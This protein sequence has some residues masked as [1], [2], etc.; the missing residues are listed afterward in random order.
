M[1]DECSRDP[2]AFHRN[3]VEFDLVDDEAREHVYR[4]LDSYI[5]YH[6]LEKV[7]FRDLRN[8]SDPEVES[9]R[10]SNKW[11]HGKRF[12][13]LFYLSRDAAVEIEIDTDLIERAVG[14]LDAFRLIG[15]SYSLHFSKD[16]ILV[17]P[18]R[19][20]QSGQKR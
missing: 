2:N 18:S 13:V 3:W 11:P 10:F 1:L 14:T 17:I 6:R 19:V 20:E 12:R 5:T 7:F 8:P 16:C 15:V 9:T 4:L